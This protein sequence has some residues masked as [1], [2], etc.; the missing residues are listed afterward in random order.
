MWTLI[1]IGLVLVVICLSFW[2][3][4]FYY[5]S[6]KNDNDEEMMGE[7]IDVA[8]LNPGSFSEASCK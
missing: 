5:F 1:F 4:F 8:S 7:I 2:L 3:I 6:N